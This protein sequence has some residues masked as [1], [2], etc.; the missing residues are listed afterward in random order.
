[1]SHLRLMTAIVVALSIASPGWGSSLRLEWSGA[2][3][4]I[5]LQSTTT[6]S[7]RVASTV[8]GS[9]LPAAWYVVWAAESDSAHSVTLLPHEVPGADLPYQV[10]RGEVTD[11]LLH[12]ESETSRKSEAWWLVRICG[13]ARVR[14][15]VRVPGEAGDSEMEVTVNGGTT[16]PFSPVPVSATLQQGENGTYVD[17]NGFFLDQLEEL[18]LT[19]PTGIETPLTSITR[20]DTHILATADVDADSFGTGTRV[21]LKWSGGESAIAAAV[22]HA[23]AAYADG[24][25]LLQFRHGEVVAPPA[26]EGPIESFQMDGILREALVNAGIVAMSRIARTF[27]PE[28]TLGRSLSGYPVKFQDLSNL[29]RALDLL[30]NAG[31][32]QDASLCG[33]R[34]AA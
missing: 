22:P 20:D 9:T 23:L 30:P 34:V 25:I 17:I 2:A 19:K 27:D 3:R 31:S 10:V 24:E 32:V 11:T 5:Q 28:D 18:R 16:M 33:L 12:Q 21:E 6:C 1:M 29:Y 26:L 13:G 15:Q 7:L 4:N 14:F 8:S